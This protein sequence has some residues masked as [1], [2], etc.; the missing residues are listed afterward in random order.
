ML[1]GFLVVLPEMPGF[2]LYLPNFSAAPCNRRYRD[3]IN[4]P[5]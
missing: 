5:H 1:F 3:I 4:T 2:G